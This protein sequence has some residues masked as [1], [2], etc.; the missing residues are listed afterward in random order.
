ML[1]SVCVCVCVDI[2]ELFR[3]KD[4]SKVCSQVCVCE[5]ERER[6]REEMLTFEFVCVY[7]SLESWN[8]CLM[9]VYGVYVCVLV[10]VCVCVSVC[11]CEWVCVCDT[12]RMCMCVHWRLVIMQGSLSHLCIYMQIDRSERYY[13]LCAQSGG[14]KINK[15]VS[16]THQS[17]EL[18][19]LMI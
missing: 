8:K 17:S 1:P 4:M 19:C 10:C 2:Q 11:L 12:H 7:L 15:A 9:F 13:V 18:L 16:H 6:E 5:R 14:A 3:K